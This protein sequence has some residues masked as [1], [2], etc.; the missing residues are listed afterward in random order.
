MKAVWSN[1]TL[2]KIK[3]F[4]GYWR[5]HRFKAWK[6]K[7]IVKFHICQEILRIRKIQ[8]T[9][10][11]ILFL[12]V[13]PWRYSASGSFFHLAGCADI[14]FQ[15]ICSFL[16]RLC[17]TIW[18]L[19]SSPKSGN[20]FKNIL[21]YCYFLFNCPIPLFEETRNGYEH[22]AMIVFCTVVKKPIF[23]SHPKVIDEFFNGA[24][25][26]LAPRDKCFR[27]P[28]NNAHKMFKGIDINMW[29]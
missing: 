3:A 24:R 27:F 13:L 22:G 15:P 2:K 14:Y 4:S 29:A 5:N 11:F 1:Y 19:F 10:V 26:H 25:A 23:L 20:Q 8:F 16:K 17:L 6:I 9:T 28:H 18:F 12:R 7:K 21:L